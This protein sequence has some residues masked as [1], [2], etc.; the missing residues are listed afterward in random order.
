EH[1]SKQQSRKPTRCQCGEGRCGRGSERQTHPTVPPGY[2]RRHGRKRNSNATREAPTMPARDLQ[3]DL[4]EEQA[5]SCGVAER[6]V[7]V[8]TPGNAGRA[9]GP[10][11]K[12]SVRRDRQPGD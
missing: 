2:W 5:R 4:R 7:V 6:P 8:T 1:A 11:F 9:K 12:V 10:W 3:R